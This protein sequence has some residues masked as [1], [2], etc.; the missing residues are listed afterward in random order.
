[1][2][3][4]VQILFLIVLLTA[5]GNRQKVNDEM[6][7]S[8]K[9][10]KAVADPR[11]AK[12]IESINRWKEMESSFNGA[13]SLTEKDSILMEMFNAKSRLR[14]EM[15]FDSIMWTFLQ[16]ERTFS[17][18]F[19]SNSLHWFV[20]TSGDNKVRMYSY[21]QYAGKAS[22]GRTII[23]YID[24]LGHIRVKELVFEK[25]E[26]GIFIPPVFKTIRKTSKG[27]RLYG[28]TALSSHE[29]HECEKLLVDTFFVGGLAALV[30]G[31]Q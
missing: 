30:P 28:G 23:Q 17:Y 2:K 7:D 14:C 15:L 10:F 8:L 31:K 24:K 27:Y 20:A 9:P 6:K 18:P 29:Y 12:F 3:K 26:Y 25:P 4:T 22:S 16:D 1:M 19:K 21:D 11:A 5:C 13:K